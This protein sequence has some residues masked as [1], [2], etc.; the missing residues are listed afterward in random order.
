MALSAIRVQTEALPPLMAIPNRA[1]SS[2]LFSS[3]PLQTTATFDCLSRVFVA[4][5]VAG[6]LAFSI[7][8]P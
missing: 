4:D 2:T 5:F 7:Y 3:F 8:D 1:H 6:H